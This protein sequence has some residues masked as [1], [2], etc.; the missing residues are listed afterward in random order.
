M[1][2]EGKDPAGDQTWKEEEA[3]C[4]GADFQREPDTRLFGVEESHFI[5]IEY[6]NNC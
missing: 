5:A 3:A 4:G 2:N 6:R 1:R